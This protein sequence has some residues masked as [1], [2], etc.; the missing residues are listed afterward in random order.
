M[1]LESKKLST[2]DTKMKPGHHNTNWTHFCDTRYVQFTG[3]SASA[4]ELLIMSRNSVVQ[5][6]SFCSTRVHWIMRG[7][8]QLS[9]VAAMWGGNTGSASM[10]AASGSG[11]T[12]TQCVCVW[13]APRELWWFHVFSIRNRKPE[14]HDPP[15]NNPGNQERRR[16][17]PENADETT[18]VLVTKTTACTHLTIHQQFDYET[19]INVTRIDDFFF[20]VSFYYTH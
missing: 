3:R 2:F 10:L 4:G 13:V 11:G 9:P 6:C 1:T 7:Q 14:R 5:G 12:G 17:V 16:C 15:F 18:N 19:T 20:N 8:R